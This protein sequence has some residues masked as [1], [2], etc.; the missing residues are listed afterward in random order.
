MNAEA[1]EPVAALDIGTNTVLLLIAELDSDGAL[2]VLEEQCRTP[3]LGEGLARSGRIA[4]AALERGYAALEEFAARIT[5]H[6][7]PPA[8]VRAVGTAVV[9]RAANAQ[10]FLE[11]VRARLGL[12]IEILSEAEEARLGAA[13]VQAELGALRAAVIDVGGGSTEYA[14]ADGARRLSIPIGAVVL[15]ECGLGWPEK[16]ALAASLAR[17]FPEQDARGVLAVGLGGTAVNLA[18]LEQGLAAF[19]PQQ[20]EGVV[21]EPAAARRWAERLAGLTLPERL[22]L[23]IEPERASILPEGLLCLA[24][25]LER[26]K[27]GALRVSG[28][29]LRYG[30]ARGLLEKNRA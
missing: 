24:A 19:D 2:R 30:V 21:L 17:S 8:R 3:R 1:R 27:P 6:R 22:R 5:S 18:C 16:A 15:A 28:R 10:A 25:A 11:G 20:A 4:P 23:P 9:R 26:L 7:I 12:V 13:A 29:G 14:S